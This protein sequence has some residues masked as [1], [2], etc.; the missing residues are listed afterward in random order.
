M[1]RTPARM[2]LL[3]ACE[4]GDIETARSCLD[5]GADINEKDTDGRTSLHHVCRFRGPL[6][7]AV[8]LVDHGADIN[9]RDVDKMTPLHTACKYG[10][11]GVACLLVER[12]ADVNVKTIGCF[13]PLHWACRD[14]HTDTVRLL[15]EAGAD[16]HARSINSHLLPFDFACSNSLPEAVFLLLS[17]GADPGMVNYN[18]RTPLNWAVEALTSNDPGRERIIDWYREHHPEAM[19]EAW[20]TRGPWI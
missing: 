12:G 17:H 5:H 13:T 19:M 7:L 18:G 14:G 4:E 8:L 10:D 20:C 11:T 6:A 1:T 15:L 2:T 3:R 9:A 16:M